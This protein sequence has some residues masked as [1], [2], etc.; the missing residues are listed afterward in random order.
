MV[1]VLPDLLGWRSRKRL[2]SMNPLPF[3]STA[4]NAAN[5]PFR[6]HCADI[7]GD[8]GTFHDIELA[9]MCKSMLAKQTKIAVTIF[10][11]HGLPDKG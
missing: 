1:S 11:K 3:D 7:N 2:R 5:G 4:Y 9:R 6:L 8:A 10:D